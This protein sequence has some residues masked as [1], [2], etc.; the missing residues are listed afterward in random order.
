VSG[1]VLDLEHAPGYGPAGLAYVLLRTVVGFGLVLTFI[2]FGARY[3]GSRPRGLGWAS[4]G[5]LPFYVIHHPV[6]V[7]V[8]V[9][10][11]GLPLTLWPK[12]GL[13][14]AVSLVLSLA[15]YQAIVIAR[16]WLAAAA[17]RDAEPPPAS[18]AEL[19]P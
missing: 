15:V 14:V 1:A 4:R 13:I 3:L 9:W 7:V 2:G 19:N 12:F 16:G 8:A 6:I 17:R 5:V 18:I 11:V 10:A